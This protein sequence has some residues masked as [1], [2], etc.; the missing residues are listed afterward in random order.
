VE[1]EEFEKLDKVLHR[2][3][4]TLLLQ[5]VGGAAVPPLLLPLVVVLVW[6]RSCRPSSCGPGRV[7]PPPSFLRMTF[8]SPLPSLVHCVYC[9][10]LSPLQVMAALEHKDEMAARMETVTRLAVKV[11]AAAAAAGGGAAICKSHKCGNGICETYKPG[12]RWSLRA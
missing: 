4:T 7:Y 10:P 12:C 1:D 2:S 6:G 5:P 11:S 9:P 3:S 8:T